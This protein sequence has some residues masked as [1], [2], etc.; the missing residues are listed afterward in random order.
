MEVR[1]VSTYE[2][3]PPPPGADMTERKKLRGVEGVKGKAGKRKRRARSRGVGGLVEKEMD[4]GE[5][6]G[7]GE[8]RGASRWISFRFGEEACCLQSAIYQ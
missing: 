7:E 4:V 2:Y 6:E 5:E 8:G 1:E 3:A